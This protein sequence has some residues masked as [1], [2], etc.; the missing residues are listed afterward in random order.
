MPNWKSDHRDGDNRHD[1][2]HGQDMDLSSRQ[3]GA[4]EKSPTET[5]PPNEPVI[6]L[7]PGNVLPYAPQTNADLIAVFIKKVHDW[8]DVG[9]IQTATAIMAF[10]NR[11]RRTGMMG[12]WGSCIWGR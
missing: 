2:S 11:R 4:P 1:N 10:I 7:P 3:N 9:G 6:P 8:R 12:W 5:T